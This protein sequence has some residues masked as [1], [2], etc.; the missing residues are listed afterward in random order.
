MADQCLPEKF[1]GPF[2]LREDFS[3]PSLDDWREAAEKSLKGKTLEKL[4]RRI[5]DDVW[6][7]A[8]FTDEDHSPVPGL[9]G[10]FPF[11]RGASSSR[12]RGWEACQFF[13][14]PDP[15]VVA[16]QLAAETLR[17][18]DGAWLRF[19]TPVRRG[20]APDNPEAE[21]F[22]DSGLLAFSVRD[23]DLLLSGVH[24]GNTSIHLDGGGNGFAVAAAFIA[25]TDR[26]GIDLE[27]VKGSFNIDPLGSLAADGE[28]VYGLDRT[29]ELMTALTTWCLENTPGMR[30]VS[31]SSVPYHLAGANPVQEL[32]LALA[33]GIDYLR[34]LEKGG[35]NPADAHSQLRFVFPIGRNLFVE[36]SK[37]RAFRK[38]WSTAVNA[39]GVPESDS[40]PLIHALS[41]ERTTTK[42]DPWVNLLRATIATFA[43]S[44]GGADVVTVLPF[45]SRIGPSDDLGRRLAV[46]THTIL[47]EESHLDHVLDPAGGS[48]FV[49]KLTNEL[50][51]TSW[52]LFQEIESHGGIR[53]LLVEGTLA[54]TLS[55]SVESRRRNIASRREPVTG[56]ST[57][58]NLVEEAVERTSPDISGILQ[59]AT[60]ALETL[61]SLSNP[62]P[63]LDRLSHLLPSSDPENAADIIEAAVEAADAGAS[64][65]QL[66]I[67]LQTGSRPTRRAPLPR[68]YDAAEY[69]TL[70]DASDLLMAK[71]GVRPQ[72]FLA[73]MGPISEHKARA[74]FAKN[75][76]EAGGIEVLEEGE[77]PDVDSAVEAFAASQTAFACICSSDSRY[78]DVAPDL[79]SGLKR[80]GAQKVFLAG[81]PG[82]FEEMWR[83]A[84]ID[85]FIYVGCDVLAELR[86]IYDVEGVA[87]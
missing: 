77:F 10:H 50:V 73:T 84:G 37:I 20:I 85:S 11:T 27:E 3:D 42:R 74:T 64:T 78:P 75:F 8:L 52:A 28:A 57:W 56:V 32:A 81:R 60:T 40:A 43:A 26:Q 21:E 45:D 25:A 63:L 23:M 79:A 54:D 65:A 62:E 82:E 13:D 41:S 4:K 48:W 61:H 67:A 36:A 59:R 53:H 24:V 12:S 15:E 19:A 70:R 47:R 18:A 66:A 86:S 72:V 1:S 2:T 16:Q 17:G 22:N 38:L 80:K 9:P 14:F 83:A 34:V 35:M 29:F 71:K 87:S 49:E 39:C 31:V 58:P 30:T 46:N 76:F 33:T 55:G 68:L 5:A 51:E 6:T 69:E 44:I 7:Q